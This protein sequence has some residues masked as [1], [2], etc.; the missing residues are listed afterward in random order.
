[1]DEGF[2][3]IKGYVRVLCVFK[4]IGVSDLDVYEVVVLAIVLSKACEDALRTIGILAAETVEFVLSCGMLL[5]KP[6]VFASLV[7]VNSLVKTHDAG[8]LIFELV[9]LMNRDVTLITEVSAIVLAVL[10]GLVAARYAVLDL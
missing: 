1:M 3:I 9:A 8:H 6:V 10:S 2:L 7:D 4:R 5:A